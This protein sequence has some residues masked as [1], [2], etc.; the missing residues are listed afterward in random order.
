MHYGTP[1]KIGLFLFLEKYVILN[2]FCLNGLRRYQSAGWI[3]G[4]TAAAV[5]LVPPQR[6]RTHRLQ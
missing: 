1:L 2:R 3:E 4:R 5:A 6:N